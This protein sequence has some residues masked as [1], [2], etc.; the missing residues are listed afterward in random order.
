[1]LAV[2]KPNLSLFWIGDDDTNSYK[3]R[4]AMSNKCWTP[5]ESLRCFSTALLL[6]VQ[7]YSTVRSYNALFVLPMQLAPQPG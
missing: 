7:A 5:V 3:C 6:S 4:D 2:P 1:M